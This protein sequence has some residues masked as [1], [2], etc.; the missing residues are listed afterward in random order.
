MTHGRWIGTSGSRPDGPRFKSRLVCA[1]IL[2]VSSF[3]DASKCL[4]FH[5]GMPCKN[6]GGG[7]TFGISESDSVIYQ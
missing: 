6:I 7:I 4:D 3:L 1:D 5:G 2:I